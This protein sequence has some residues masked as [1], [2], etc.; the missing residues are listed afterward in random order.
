MLPESPGA[1]VW[2]TLDEEEED[3]D[4]EDEGLGSPPKLMLMLGNSALKPS[5]HS[6]TFILSPQLLFSVMGIPPSP[7]L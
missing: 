6:L 1:P 3:D 4:E 5:C 2:L 7:V